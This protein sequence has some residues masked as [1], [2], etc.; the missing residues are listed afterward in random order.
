MTRLFTALRDDD[1][2]LLLA[3]AADA[4]SRQRRE[5]I[6][7]VAERYGPLVHTF[8]VHPATRDPD[9]SDQSA[10]VDVAAAFR[11]AYGVEGEA[12]LVIRPD[13]YVGMRHDR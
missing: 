13:G 3:G 8:V 6:L 5:H 10:L 9:D 1:Y 12:M 11:R 7:R 4:G 2:S